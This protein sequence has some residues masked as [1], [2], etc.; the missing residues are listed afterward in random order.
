MKTVFEDHFN[1]NKLDDKK[2]PCNGF[3]RFKGYPHEE[4]R[5]GNG[6]FQQYRPDQVKVGDGVL[7]ISARPMT[8][9]ERMAWVDRVLDPKFKYTGAQLRNLLVVGWVSGQISSYPNK[10]FGPGMKLSAEIGVPV[11]AQGWPAV[12]GFDDVNV[13]EVDVFEG[14]GRAATDPMGNASQGVH[15]FKSGPS[16]YHAGGPKFSVATAGYRTFWADWTDPTQI[17]FGY[18]GVTTHT[19]AAGPRMTKPMYI[20]IGHA[21]GAQNWPWIGMPDATT[22]QAQ[23]FWIKRVWVEKP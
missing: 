12:W 17:V 19:V 8:S 1:G 16:G 22:P 7:Q 20:I 6:E 2:W 9:K 15:D 14:S 11:G 3:E 13:T 23:R 4:T 18:D 5:P 10:P 21:I